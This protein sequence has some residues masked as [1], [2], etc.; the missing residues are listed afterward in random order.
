MSSR[1]WRG[2]IG[3]VVMVVASGA[4]LPPPATAQ[5]PQSPGGRCP[6]APAGQGP[7]KSQR[8]PSHAGGRPTRTPCTRRAL[9]AHA[10]VRGRKPAASP[11]CP[12]S[13]RS[14]RQRCSSRRLKSSVASVTKTSERTWRY[15]E[16]EYTCACSARAIRQDVDIPSLNVT[17]HPVARRRRNAGRDQLYALPAVPMRIMSPRRPRRPIFATPRDT[18]ADIEA[19]KFR[20]TGET[21]RQR[22]R[23]RCRAF[24]SPSRGWSGAL[25][26]TPPSWPDRC[27]RARCW[28]AAFTRSDG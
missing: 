4:W 14:S 10:D 7:A 9:H 11:W 5:A 12:T 17:Q 22:L 1:S 8:T 28:P 6:G 20:A 3:V 23:L 25:A 13:S 2:R 19:R 24:G 26:S 27:R 16:C 21:L 18:F 15:S